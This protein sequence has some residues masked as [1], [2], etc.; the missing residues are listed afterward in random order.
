M[1]QPMNPAGTGR[2]SEGNQLLP[3]PADVAV[4]QAGPQTATENGG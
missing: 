1:P 3:P 4:G 2:T